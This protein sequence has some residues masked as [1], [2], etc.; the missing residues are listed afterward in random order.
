MEIKGTTEYT[1]LSQQKDIWYQLEVINQ[2][3]W[4][5]KP[6]CFK[7]SGKILIPYCLN[8]NTPINTRQNKSEIVEIIT[9][10]MKDELIAMGYTINKALLPS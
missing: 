8:K 3:D 1:D 5:K 6:V 10:E 9:D 7:Y 4:K 2:F